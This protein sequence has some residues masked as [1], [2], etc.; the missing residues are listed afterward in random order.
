[1]LL[2]MYSNYYNNS[3]CEREREKERG[4]LLM[5][6]RL[7]TF[8]DLKGRNKIPGL[9]ILI[10]VSFSLGHIPFMGVSTTTTELS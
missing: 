8:E 7:G 2:S 3:V 9:S 6:Y 4:R 10:P 1:M 5:S